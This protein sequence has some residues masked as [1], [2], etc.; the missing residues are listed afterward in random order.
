M[1]Q[2]KTMNCG[3]LGGPTSELSDKDP[4]KAILQFCEGQVKT[5]QN[6]SCRPEI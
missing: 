6:N 4:I 3:D 5:M 1:L 2:W